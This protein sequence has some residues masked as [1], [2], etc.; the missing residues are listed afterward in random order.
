ML[1]FVIFCFVVFRR[2][3]CLCPCYLATFRMAKLLMI[4]AFPDNAEIQ[5]SEVFFNSMSYFLFS[6]LPSIFVVTFPEYLQIHHIPTLHPR[7][8]LLVSFSNES[9]I[10]FLFFEN[11]ILIEYLHS[12]RKNKDIPLNVEDYF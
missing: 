10:P 12:Q 11:V 9:E 3:S 5:K 2:M 6:S 1:K 4:H 8:K 7:V